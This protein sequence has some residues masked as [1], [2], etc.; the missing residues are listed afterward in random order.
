MLNRPLRYA[1]LL[2]CILFNAFL[3]TPG[4]G[5]AQEEEQSKGHGF[6]YSTSL[7]NNIRFNRV[8]GGFLGGE[9]DLRNDHV[10]RT[11]LSTGAG[12]GFAMKDP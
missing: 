6:S 8:E 7:L 4:T 2:V 1:P 12:Y 11:V 9:I 5:A 10:P 3:A